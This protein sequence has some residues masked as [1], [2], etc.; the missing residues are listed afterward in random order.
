MAESCSELATISALVPTFSIINFIHI[1]QQ[2]KDDILIAQLAEEPEHPAPEVLPL[3]MTELLADS[4]GISLEDVT[5]LWNELRVLV[6][7]THDFV[8]CSHTL[9][10]YQ[11][12]HLTRMLLCE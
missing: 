2:P 4:C 5:L 10:S 1:A 9:S 12:L 7:G 3:S 8:A 6:W 11:F